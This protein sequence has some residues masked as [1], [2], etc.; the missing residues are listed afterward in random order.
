MGKSI[1]SQ[2][3]RKYNHEN[4]EANYYDSTE[5]NYYKSNTLNNQIILQMIIIFKIIMNMNTNIMD[6][7]LF[8]Q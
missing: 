1:D 7:I 4:K 8:K 3:D 5:L 2:I 6:L